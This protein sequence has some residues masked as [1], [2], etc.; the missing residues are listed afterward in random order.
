[1]KRIGHSSRNT[2]SIENII[3]PICGAQIIIGRL[4]DEKSEAI[5]PLSRI[6]TE[7]FAIIAATA[8]HCPVRARRSDN[9]EQNEL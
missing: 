5:E 9:A 8:A 7:T 6:P 3:I 1:M 2:A 4:I